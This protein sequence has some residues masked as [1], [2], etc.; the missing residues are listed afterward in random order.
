MKGI[1]DHIKSTATKVYIGKQ[2]TCC[3][4]CAGDYHYADGSQGDVSKVAP[5]I[6][7]ILQALDNSSHWDGDS[8]KAPRGYTKKFNT[9]KVGRTHIWN[10]G[11]AVDIGRKLYI[12]YTCLLYTSPSPRDKRQSRM[13]SSA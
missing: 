5:T 10:N 13:P 1:I 7:L 9:R 4:G 12:V 6:D 3:C 11:I 8:G 2:N